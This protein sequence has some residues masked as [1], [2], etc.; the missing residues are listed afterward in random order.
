MI[1]PMQPYQPDG[2]VVAT[3]EPDPYAGM[4]EVPC[5][6]VLAPEGVP[7]GDDPQR[8]FAPGSLT[9]APLP[10]PFKWQEKQD[11]GHEGACVTGRMDA[12]WRDGALIRWVGVVDNVSEYGRELI[13]LRQADYVRGVSITVDDLDCADIEYV[14]PVPPMGPEPVV[15]MGMDAED[16]PDFDHEACAESEFCMSPKHPGPCKGSKRGGSKPKNQSGGA[17]KSRHGGYDKASGRYIKP[18]GSGLMPKGWTPA[19][20][21]ALEDGQSFA[22]GDVL[23]DDPNLLPTDEQSMAPMPSMPMP[24]PMMDVKPIKLIFHAGR[25]RSGTVVA[26]PA[27]VEAT[28]ELGES[29]IPV[30]VQS[31]PTVDGETVMVDAGSMPVTASATCGTIDPKWRGGPTMVAGASWTITIPEVWPESWFEE[32]TEAPPIGALNITAAGRVYGYLAPAGVT[33]RGFRGK[34]NVYAPTRIDYSEFQNK[35]CLVSSADGQVYKINAGNVTFDCGH[36]SP[37]DPRRQDPSWAAAHYENTCSIAARVRVGENR[38][39]TWVAGALLHGIT[40]DAVERMMASALSGD[41]Q[42]GK[43]KGALLVPVEGFPRAQTASVR[44]RADE[45]EQLSMVA[46]S[47]PVFYEAPEETVTLSKDLYDSLVAAA[48]EPLDVDRFAQYSAERFDELS[49]ERG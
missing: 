16:D 45:D 14:Y 48:F 23:D 49:R 44:V 19:K 22:A 3:T 10:A 4:A 2:E 26:E 28:F 6:G 13:R 25:I 34:R 39:G 7:S 42:D 31:Q 38:N 29:P 35:G 5:Y 9:W 11:E 17:L 37:V 40:P 24:M 15:Q 41:W 33:H 47:V 43:L 36:A 1:S 32:P 18:S 12:I 27:F 21:A 30:P 46:S 20:G 8:E